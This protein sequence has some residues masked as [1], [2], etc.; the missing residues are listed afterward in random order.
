MEKLEPNVVAPP[1]Q[2]KEKVP[3][4][5]SRPEPQTPAPTPVTV[6]PVLSNPKE[7][8]PAS[9]V[10]LSRTQTVPAPMPSSV[11]SYNELQAE[12]PHYRRSTF[13][14]TEPLR[15][16]PSTPSQMRRYDSN[17]LLSENSIAS[18]RFDLTDNASYPE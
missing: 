9:S 4:P 18:S 16:T 2:A 15:S 13:V 1:N 5:Q 12:Y 17:S 3:S 14:S 7:K 11:S 6:Q 10:P 8:V